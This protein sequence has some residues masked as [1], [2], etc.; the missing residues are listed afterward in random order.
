M[1]YTREKM[2]ELLVRI[3]LITSEQLDQALDVQ[4]ETGGKLGEILTKNLV[5]TE[6][7]IAS[8]L[9]EQKGLRHVNLAGVEIDRNVVT[10]LPI[11]MCRRRGVIPIG[12]RSG[13]LVLAM[14]N[15]L[16][17]EAVDEAE[18]VTGFKIEAVVATASQVQYAIEKYAVASDA[19]HELE[20]VEQ[21]EAPKLPYV[22]EATDDVPVVRIVN[23]LLREAVLDGASDVHFEPTEGGV[24]VRCRI[25]GV[26][27][28]VTTLPKASQASL[29]SRIKVMADLDIT[30]RRRPQDGRIAMRLDNRS[31]DLRVATLPTPT[32]E[33]IVVRIL[34]SDMS[35]HSIDE[36]GLNIENRRILDG[37]LSRPY[38][39]ILIAG[40]TGSGKT[41]TLYAALNLLN[42]PLRKIITVEDPIEYRMAG[43][44]Q[45]AVNPRIG[46]TF[47]AGLRTILRSDPD[48]VMVGEVRDP[49]TASI[50]VRSALTGHLVLS[51]IHTND[52]PSAL[53][54][55]TDMGIEPYITSSALLGAV[56]QRLVRVLCPSCKTEITLPVEELV[57]LGFS[58]SEAV[59]LHVYKAV[60]C[61]E[62]RRTGYRGRLGVFEIMLMDG[63][64]TRLFIKNAPAEELREA[65]LAK[66]MR[67]LR[68][69]ALEKVALG[70]TS[71][72]E[73]NRAVV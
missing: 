23:Q 66:G 60:G 13:L 42:T 36:L 6:D 19:L 20:Q 21:T 52:A 73:V 14:S 18:M 44:T 30:E 61:D 59:G 62:C 4:A 34:N 47:A 28:E 33:S 49:E 56:A 45:V 72:D 12:M 2:G 25:D 48:V 51:S 69:D 5:V 46:L 15:P 24:R 3:G 16:D 17:V 55:L 57:G 10:L 41:T 65:A 68:H 38:G 11:R 70:L 26:L 27:Q 1:D 31:L 43:L 64:I 71:I 39:A 32:G 7:Q 37:M 29:L 8:A 67:T 22:S 35:F 40:P 9:A 63:D 53:T 54:R 50:A 58:E